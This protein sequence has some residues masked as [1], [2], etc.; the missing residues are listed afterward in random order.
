MASSTVETSKSSK[1]DP[2]SLPSRPAV[3]ELSRLLG[4]TWRLTLKDDERV[5]TGKFLVVDR[6]VSLVT[7]SKPIPVDS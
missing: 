4:T 7:Q 5:F 6:R 2:P 1:L 3:R